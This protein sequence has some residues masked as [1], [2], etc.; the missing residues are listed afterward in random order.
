[1]EA[2]SIASALTANRGMDITTRQAAGLRQIVYG[3]QRCGGTIIYESTTG[4]GGSGG[5][6]VYNFVIAVASH[7]IDA[8]INM[9][10]DGRQVFF[11]QESTGYHANIGCGTVSTPP[12]TSVTISGG[13]ITGI[14]ATGGSGFANVQPKDG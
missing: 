9:Y 13:V 14:T 7:Q 12:T 1:M 2:A 3:Q 5:N 4:V 11:S 6:Y 10:L 8:F